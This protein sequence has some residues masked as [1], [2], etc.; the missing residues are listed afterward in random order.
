MKFTYLRISSMFLIVVAA[1]AINACG[2]QGNPTGPDYS[3]MDNNFNNVIVA[4]EVSM[5]QYGLQFDPIVGEYLSTSD[6]TPIC[7]RQFRTN[8]LIFKKQVDLIKASM[9]KV[10]TRLA[11]SAK[12]FYR[13]IGQAQ[14]SLN[15]ISGTNAGYCELD[16]PIVKACLTSAAVKVAFLPEA[17]PRLWILPNRTKAT[18]FSPALPIPI[19]GITENKTASLRI[20]SLNALKNNVDGSTQDTTAMDI[21][22]SGESTAQV[23]QA[24]S[25]CLNSADLKTKLGVDLKSN[26]LYLETYVADLCANQVDASKLE[27]DSVA[28]VNAALTAKFCAPPA[29]LTPPAPPAL[30]ASAASAPVAAASAASAP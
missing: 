13:H 14:K 6:L 2:T 30:G 18:A 9:D 7:D 10:T 16:D 4:S 5:A 25:A 19:K 8:L 20:F 21:V 1:I 26:A 29:S 12:S 23:I 11:G 28:A 22:N 3:Q 17:D 24:Q 15:R 27:K